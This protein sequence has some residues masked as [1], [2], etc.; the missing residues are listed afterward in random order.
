MGD[1]VVITQAARHV[2]LIEQLGRFEAGN[3]IFHIIS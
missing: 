1:S 3:E 2:S